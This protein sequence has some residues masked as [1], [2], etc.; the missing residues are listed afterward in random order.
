MHW[1]FPFMGETLVLDDK[2]R[3]TVSGDFIKLPDGYTHYEMAGP[4]DGQTVVLVHGFSV[5]YFLWDPTFKALSEAGFCVLRY[6][7]FGRGYS[8][9]PFSVYHIDLFER[10][11]LE[12]SSA[13]KLAQPFDLVGLSMGGPIVTVFTERHPE[14]IRRLCLISPA[15]FNVSLPAASR[16]LHIPGLG[17][18]LFSLFA[19]QVVIASQPKDFQ[20]PERFPD[21]ADRVR[22]QMKYKGYRR[23]L[24]STLRHGPLEGLSASYQAVGQQERPIL[25]LWGRDDQT[26]PFSSSENVRSALQQAEFH[27]V[28][29]A[30]HVS[31]YERPE[32]VNPLLIDFLK[33]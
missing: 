8:D 7:L 15:G 18:I 9:R 30:R 29:E 12:L 23:A 5:P 27:V 6:D 11:L 33:K 1:E 24:L 22:P 19:E 32:I 16:L 3:A 26:V 17:E 25:L 13:L 4:P 31:H 10:Q 20:H 28:E 14:L 2:V 21:Y